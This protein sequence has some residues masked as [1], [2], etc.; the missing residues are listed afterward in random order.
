MTEFIRAIP[1]TDAQIFGAIWAVTVVGY[2]AFL[3]IRPGVARFWGR[4]FTTL[5]SLA[6][7]ASLI[8]V[9]LIAVWEIFIEP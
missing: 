7:A 3:L 1:Y 6:A 5:C 2:V 9:T 4:G 8:G